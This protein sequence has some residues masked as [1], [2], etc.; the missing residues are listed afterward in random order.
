MKK[1]SILFISLF[2]TTNLYA[3]I[4]GVTIDYRKNTKSE[5]D[6]THTSFYA[7]RDN[8]ISSFQ[9]TCKKYGV[10][11]VPIPLDKTMIKEYTNMFDGIVFT[12]NLY[13]VDPKLYGQKKLNDTVNLDDTLKTDFEI[14]LF[15]SY[16]K[17]NKPIFGICGGYQMMNVVLG[18]ELYQD[19]PSQ[20]DNPLTHSADAKSC[21][22]KISIS[23]KDGIF[24]KALTQSKESEKKLCVNSSHHQAISKISQMLDIAAISPDGI[25][26]GY[27][28]KNHPFLIGVQWHP[29][30]EVTKFDKA[31]INEFCNIVA[32]D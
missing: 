6:Y 9:K 12:G 23:Q 2:F 5:N 28:A 21:A 32:K 29:E 25:I 7:L 14:E 26:E 20:I 27:Q 4:V 15:K 31:L 13:D 8:Y 3:K 30:Y 16:Y 19:I 1:F 18:G 17:T 24:A 10:T 22:H 11:V